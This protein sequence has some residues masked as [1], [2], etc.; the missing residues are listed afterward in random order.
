MMPTPKILVGDA[1]EKLSEL[2]SESIQCCVTSPPYYGLR[3]YGDA[4]QLGSEATPGLYVDRLI[5][6]SRE[7]RR[8]LKNDGTFWLNLGDSY[9]NYRPGVGQ[10]LSKQTLSRTDQDMPQK[11]ARRGLKQAGFKEKDRM[12]I[13]ARV[14]IAL[15]DDGWYLRDEIVWHKPN[16]TPESV[17]DRTSRAHEMIYLLTKNKDYYYDAEAIKQ[18]YSEA[19]MPRMM[20]GVSDHHKNVDGAPGQTPHTMNQPRLHSSYRGQATKDY[21]LALAQNPSDTKRRI[22]E[23]ILNGNGMANKKSVWTVNT[24]PCR[25]AHFAT[26]PP[27]LIKPCILAGSRPGDTILDPFGGRGTT[28]E[29]ALELARNCILIELNPKFAALCEAVTSDT[30]PGFAF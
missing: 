9:Y 13:P 3:D 20:R 12:M 8:V 30:T 26:Y 2:P 18:P 25:D 1:L 6:I 22:E 29:V 24:A 17:T 16:P 27:D 21:E 14:A 11:C 15:C 19:T 28:G 7:I 23:S 4:R 10:M 5:A